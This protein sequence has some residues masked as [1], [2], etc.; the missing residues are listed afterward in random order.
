M[1]DLK[2][3]NDKLVDE[4]L[5]LVDI[6]EERDKKIENIEEFKEIV[7]EAL[8][9]ECRWKE[10]GYWLHEEYR[11]YTKENEKS[12]RAIILCINGYS[13]DK[14]TFKHGI[15]SVS[16]VEVYDIYYTDCQ[17]GGFIIDDTKLSYEALMSIR[18]LKKVK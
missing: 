17:G 1:E 14:K 16:E 9:G 6:I 7:E 15:N 12:F 18:K 5:H 11:D 2:N 13:Q 8:K 10:Y 4:V 3:K